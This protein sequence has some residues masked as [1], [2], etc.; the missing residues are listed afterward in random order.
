MKISDIS[1]K[2]PMFTTMLNL[3]IIV[4]GLISF[5][6]L[7]VDQ[8][9]D[10][11]FPF[12][13][14]SVE[15]PGANPR[16]AEE[17]L[18]KP[19]ERELR[20]IE[21]LKQ[22]TGTARSGIVSVELEFELNVKSDQALVNVKDKVGQV[23]FPVGAK[24]PYIEKSS[25]NDTP[26]MF[27]AVSADTITPTDLMRFINDN[28]KPKIQQVEGVG[29]I[30]VSGYREPELHIKLNQSAINAVNLTPLSISE[31]IS[32]QIVTI[33][34]GNLNQPDKVT[35]MT[36][37]NIP[38]S[39]SQVENLP[40]TTAKGN[41]LRLGDLA[42]IEKGLSKQI[43]YGELNHKPLIIMFVNKQSG[44]NLV[45]IAK[46]INKKIEELKKTLPS[47][48]HLQV[49]DEDYSFIENSLEA[50][51][52]DIVLGAM[53][54]VLVVFVF[55]H[56]WRSTVIS[57]VAIPTSLVGTFVMMSLLGFTLNWMTLLALTISIGILVDDAIVVI[58]NIHRH[59]KMGKNSIHAAQIGTKE[60][61][62]AALAVTLTI[63][64]VF[65]PVS[66]M[67]GIVGRYF[68]QFGLTV[69]VAVLISL[70]V[71]FTMVPMLSSKMLVHTQKQKH[72][73]F[74]TIDNAFDQFQKF[75]TRLMQKCLN[76]RFTVVGA[77]ILILL[78]SV[79][80]LKFVAVTM[81]PAFDSGKAQINVTLADGTPLQ[82]SIERGQEIGNYIKS[83]PGVTNVVMRVGGGLNSVNSVIFKIQL[84]DE[85]LRNFTQSEFESQLAKD[86]KKFLP[87][88]DEK[89]N[90]G[91]NHKALEIALFANNDEILQQ[92]SNQV[93]TYMNSLP[94]VQNASTNFSPSYEYRIEPDPMKS[95]IAKVSPA[96][97]ANTVKFLY[98]DDSYVG[99]YND[100]GNLENMRL[101]ISNTNDQ[102]LN[103][104]LGVYI[105]RN[106]DTPVLLSSIASVNKIPV[107]QTITHIDGLKQLSVQ[108]NYAGKDLAGTTK[109][110]YDYVAKT[111]PLDVSYKLLGDSNELQETMQ[112]VVIALG[113]GSLFVFMVLCSQF[114]NVV[115][116]LAIMVSIPLCFSGAFLAL[117]ISRQPLTIYSMIGIILLMGLVVKN[118]ILLIE[119]AQQKIRSGHS[120]YD[121][122]IESSKTRL[123]PI[124]MT[125][126]TMIV[127]MMPML[128]GSGAGHE[129]RTNMS[130]TVVG[131]LI[132]STLLTLVVVPC[133]YSLL[134]NI[135]SLKNIRLKISRF[136]L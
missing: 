97:L 30:Y 5:Q 123:R 122:L 109:K 128:L 34:A 43:S 114:E 80:L 64:A 70:F 1:I 135:K 54:A 99:K 39:V 90:F 52:D 134:C 112:Q 21:G 33:P 46:N 9:P 26:V 116:P 3:L 12:V 36:T 61:G 27:L 106:G 76:F 100:E 87:G 88:P 8:S 19:L 79:V 40:M 130:I 77:A 125:T 22:M 81:Q 51:G 104:L 53:L 136:K 58:E 121:A 86:I 31:Q 124:I 20:S 13:F 83:Y 60:I 96:D 50:V 71:A 37:Y 91:W 95:A 17:Q 29:A 38:N 133:V 57:A 69:V 2:H 111:H 131:G 32:N 4:L 49:I 84:V 28:L 105:Q 74:I 44:G 45:Q 18:L 47:T 65:I 113:L 48:I 115:A 68:V 82:K 67:Q 72:R 7:G 14:V 108:A 56:D 118:A 132:S 62:L 94:D 16:T 11:D 127:G 24:T 103:N 117:L 6:K 41:I 85:K 75:Y 35:P 55:L 42:Q 73:Y 15:Y 25:S 126:L 119:F 107:E 98:S 23:S 129:A 10:V 120:I 66:F 102:S 101:M 92:Y 93:A 78:V 63:V 89:V 110:I 59:F